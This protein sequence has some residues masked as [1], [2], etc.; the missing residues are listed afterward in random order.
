MASAVRKI[1]VASVLITAGVAMALAFR[2]FR[3]PGT[4]R[5]IVFV[6]GVL[7]VWKPAIAC[8]AGCLTA[9]LLHDVVRALT[10]A[11][12]PAWT[13]L[14][15]RHFLVALLTTA[16]VVGLV[17]ARYDKGQSAPAT[18]GAWLLAGLAVAH[19]ASLVL[20]FLNGRIG[21]PAARRWAN[22]L[23]AIAASGS[24]VW[25]AALGIAANA[26]LTVAAYEQSSQAVA[27]AA[28]DVSCHRAS[29]PGT[30]SRP[31]AWLRG[32]AVCAPGRVTV[33]YEWLLDNNVMKSIAAAHKRQQAR[34]H[35]LSDG[36]CQDGEYVGHWYLD[37]D[38]SAALGQ[39]LCYRTSGVSYIEWS[40]KRGGT[41][42]VA[43]RPGGMHGLYEWWHQG[44]WDV[45]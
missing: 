31:P 4:D 9:A 18:T 2:V 32:T 14:G 28:L 5:A 23:V 15:G 29:W 26:K 8:G 38:R 13:G 16:G 33:T 36:H 34:T 39:L 45:P 35:S 19:V 6:T 11:R 17:A 10:G 7:H 1:V 40:D 3:A 37:A 25:V 22:R 43:S 12:G 24:G 30:A 41:Y 21:R 42:A 44:H 20:G 27:A